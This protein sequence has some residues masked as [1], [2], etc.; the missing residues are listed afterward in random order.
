MVASQE[1]S[2]G[3]CNEV[4]IVTSIRRELD[5]LVLSFYVYIPVF[6]SVD[7]ITQL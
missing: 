3:R 1:A 7:S 5:D 6:L 4:R 2:S